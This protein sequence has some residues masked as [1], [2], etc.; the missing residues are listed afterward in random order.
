[1]AGE[2]RDPKEENEEGSNRR[3]RKDP[4]GGGKVAVGGEGRI[5]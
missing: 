3:R 1:M 4:I 5:Q 2:S